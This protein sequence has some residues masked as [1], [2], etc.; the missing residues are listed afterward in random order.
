ME[1]MDAVQKNARGRG[2]I[3]DVQSEIKEWYTPPYI[4]DGLPIQFDLDPCSPTQEFRESIPLR[5]D[6]TA[7]PD[8]F[9][10]YKPTP[11]KRH[12]T[13]NEDGLTS[14]WLQDETVWLNPPYGSDIPAWVKKLRAHNN[15]IMLVFT[16]TDTAW[17]HEQTPDAVLFI[18]SRVKFISPQTGTEYVWNEQKQM[19]VKGSP[20]APSMLLAYGIECVEALERSSLRGTLMYTWGLCDAPEMRTQGGLFDV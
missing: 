17:F 19:Y 15:G 5:R 18:Q 6:P 2:L 4:F 20:G 8:V 12:L 11:C 10:R 1:L 9:A 13:A 3:H 7:K 16:R 14:P